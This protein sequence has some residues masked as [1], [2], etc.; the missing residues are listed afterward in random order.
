MPLLV[1][2]AGKAAELGGLEQAYRLAGVILGE[3]D[4][5]A[6]V[7]IGLRPGLAALADD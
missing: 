2:F 7:G 4:G 1:K 3:V 5:L 6:D